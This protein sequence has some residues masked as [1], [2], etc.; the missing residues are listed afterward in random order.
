MKANLKSIIAVSTVCLPAITFIVWVATYWW[1]LRGERYKAFLQPK[2][3]PLLIL[4][5]VLL[6]IF[7]AASIFQFQWKKRVAHIPDIWLQA[8]ILIVPAI[9]LWT[10][11]GQ[12]LGTHALTQKA[13]DADNIDSLDSLSQAPLE[14]VSGPDSA[15]MPKSGIRKE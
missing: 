2:L 9:F 12:S 7:M 10:V 5:M 8:A 14:D 11:Y 3:W 15:V 6:L 4:A 13:F 1:L